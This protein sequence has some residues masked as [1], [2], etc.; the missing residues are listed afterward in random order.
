MQRRRTRLANTPVSSITLA[1]VNHYLPCLCCQTL[2]FDS[3]VSRLSLPYQA[4]AKTIPI[5]CAFRTKRA[6]KNCAGARTR[7]CASGRAAD[8]RLVSLKLFCFALVDFISIAHASH[9]HLFNFLF[10]CKPKHYRASV[11]RPRVPALPCCA[12]ATL[13]LHFILFIPFPCCPTSYCT[14]GQVSRGHVCLL[15]HAARVR[16]RPLR[17]L[18]CRRAGR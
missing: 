8:A 4:L 17:A 10:V 2:T 16:S 5:V 14:T 18:R 3:S 6:A 9:I 7:A 11:V 1:S 13:Q 15:Y 12:S